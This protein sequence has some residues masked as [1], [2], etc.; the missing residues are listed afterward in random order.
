MKVPAG[1]VRVCTP[2]RR[3]R[4]GEGK[5]CQL[6][7][8]S[9]REAFGPLPR[10]D[11]RVDK[12]GG[13][14]LPCGLGAAGRWG[15]RGAG[16]RRD[17]A[18][19]LAGGGAHGR[20][21]PRGETRAVVQGARRAPDVGTGPERRGAGRAEAGRAGVSELGPRVPGVRRSTRAP[22]A[23]RDATGG[24]APA[25]RRE[26]ARG[27]GK[28]G[29][30]SDPGR[31]SS[32]RGSGGGGGGPQLHERGRAACGTSGRAHGPRAAGEAESG[33][34][35]GGRD[36]GGD[37]RPRRPF[38][39]GERPRPGTGHPRP[40]LAPVGVQRV[41]RPGP[42]ETA[43]QRPGMCRRGVTRGDLWR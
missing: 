6:P 43:R 41:P 19:S 8:K 27:A 31:A 15:A 33:G 35:E 12:A 42:P 3:P 1:F 16:A 22:G 18:V 21:A 13:P 30:E 11:I 5:G 23:S 2:P 38:T 9:P 29:R 17:L 34:G 25:G 40:A 37:G 14:L 36:G 32:E 4:K 20:S 39:S 24:R 10:R 28:E 26:T 7:G